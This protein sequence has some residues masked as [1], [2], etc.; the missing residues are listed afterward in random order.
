MTTLSCSQSE[1]AESLDKESSDEAGPSWPRANGTT[2]TAATASVAEWPRWV[3]KYK[4]Q[5]IVEAVK[6]GGEWRHFPKKIG[7]IQQAEKFSFVNVFLAV[8]FSEGEVL[9]PEV[10]LTDVAPRVP[11]CPK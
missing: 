4:M 3:T 2:G 1:L 8:S 6:I 9:F 10:C 11:S 5:D 7:M